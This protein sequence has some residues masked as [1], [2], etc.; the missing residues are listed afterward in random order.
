MYL[1]SVYGTSPHINGARKVGI[2]LHIDVG[3]GH[4]ILDQNLTKCVNND[5]LE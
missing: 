4:T 1:S 3:F 5:M 2:K